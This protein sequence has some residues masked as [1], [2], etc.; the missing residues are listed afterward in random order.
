MTILKVKAASKKYQ[1][2]LGHGLLDKISLKRLVGKKEVLLLIDNKV[3]KHFV[4]KVENNIK[5]SSAAKIKLLTVNA[6]EKNKSFL[7]I[8]RSY[9]FLIKNN[10]S[11]D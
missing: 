2:H 6:S 5:K 7:Y 11:R 8:S 1:I 10:F 4:K 9:D 3:P